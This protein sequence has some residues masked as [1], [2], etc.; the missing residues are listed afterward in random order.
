MRLGRPPRAG[1]GSGGWVR[2]G[3]LVWAALTSMDRPGRSQVMQHWDTRSRIGAI[4]ALGG[5]VLATL[6]VLDGSTPSR[7]GVAVM[8]VVVA[9]FAVPGAMKGRS[10]PSCG[11]SQRRQALSFAAA[12][13]E[14][15]TVT[16]ERAERGELLVRRGFKI[17]TPVQASCAVCGVTHFWDET[18]FVPLT[19]A[20]SEAEAL[21]VA[22]LDLNTTLGAKRKT[23]GHM[24][25]SV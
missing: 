8:A 24:E 21:L 19:E 20:G 4:A 9:V 14:P 3:G 2:V 17:T 7:I 5:A 15:A 13:V 22:E 23:D 16:D 10:C 1:Q 12:T 25:P 18:R 11:A 6:A